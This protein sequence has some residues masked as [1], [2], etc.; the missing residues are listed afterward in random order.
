M[1]ETLRTAELFIVQIQKVCAHIERLVQDLTP[2]QMSWRPGAVSN[3]IGFSVWHAVRTWDA[4][5]A[6]VTG[7][8]TLHEKE[9]WSQRFGFETAGKGLFGTGIGTGFTPEEV[10]SIQLPIATMLEY[11][12]ALSTRTENYL[13]AASDETLAG[14]VNVAWWNPPGVPRALV[15]GHLI[16]HAYLHIGEAQCVRGLMGK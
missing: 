3:S 5:L 13:N 15:L 8:P 4:Y 16:T 10:A 6:I 11:L 9:N 12:T 1:E 7:E 14:I 2:E